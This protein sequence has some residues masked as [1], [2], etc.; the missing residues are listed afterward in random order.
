MRMLRRQQADDSE[1]DRFKVKDNLTYAMAA[2]ERGDQREA[3][4]LWESSLS[5]YPN[6]TKSSPLALSV[7]LG[8]RRYDEAD[9]LMLAGQKKRPN[10]PFFAKGLAQIAIARHDREEA[11]RRCAALRKRFPGVMEGYTL[12]VEALTELKR[13]DEADA[14]CAR[15]IAT[16]PDEMV[17][18]LVH[19]R[20][21]VAQENWQEALN[22]WLPVRDRF[23]WISGHLGYAEALGKL[24]SYDE[25]ETLLEAARMR[26]PTDT[27]PVTQ[28]A[29]LSEM[30]GDAPQAI[31]RWQRLAHRFPL[32]IH[33]CLQ[34]AEH[35]EKLGEPA[36]AERVLREAVEHFPNDTAPFSRLGALMMRRKEYSGA[37]GVWAEFRKTFPDVE[38]PYIRGVE[39]LRLAG[40]AAE[41][42]T[43]AQERDRRFKPG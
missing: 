30:R 5:R 20:V 15:A 36:D 33:A 22:R 14:L 1:R 42:D 43:L 40:R 24:G 7:L 39:A 23:D 2:I 10:D 6:E 21:A 34:A 31:S 13:F 3:T 29:L 32:M 26:F 28:L 11:L 19:A 12:A 8:V 9:A 37:A 16:F 41:A 27:A 25:A 17:C 38:E 18:Y 4:E 35:L